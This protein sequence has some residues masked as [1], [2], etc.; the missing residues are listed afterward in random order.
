M[1]VPIILLCLFL[2][3]TSLG[4]DMRYLFTDTSGTFSNQGYYDNQADLYMIE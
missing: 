2:V 3:A 1:R 4:D